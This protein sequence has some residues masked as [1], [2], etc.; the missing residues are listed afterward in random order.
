MNKSFLGPI[1][2]SIAA[3]I[4]GGMYVSSK[5]LLDTIPPISLLFIRYLVASIVLIAICLYRRER[6]FAI[7]HWSWFLQIGFVGYFLSI[8]TQFLGTKLSNAHL[9]SLI[10]TLSPVFLSIFAIWLL[11]EKISKK[12]ILSMVIAVLGLMIIVG[13]PSGDGENVILGN[14][15][16]IFTSM[17]WGYYSVIARKASKHYSPLQLTTVGIILATLFTFPATWV[18]SS[19]WQIASLF[20]WKI[21]LNVLYISVIATAVAFFS[22]NKGLELTPSHQAGVFFF[23]QP[24]VGSLLGWLLLGEQLTLAFML[25]SLF[26][27]GGVYYNMSGENEIRGTHNESESVSTK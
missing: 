19:H 10:T 7:K 4:W 26:I 8:G 25:G 20:D 27:I 13:L 22:W 16:L 12:Q 5:F 15:I 6:L 23:L 3:S 11:K 9:A 18:D 14:L 2:L 21:L 1:Y 17:S 24:I